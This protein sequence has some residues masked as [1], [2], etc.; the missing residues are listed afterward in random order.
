MKLTTEDTKETVNTP[1]NRRTDPSE[2][3]KIGGRVFARPVQPSLILAL[4]ERCK[5]MQ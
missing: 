5:L 2:W 4:T 1:T 3:R